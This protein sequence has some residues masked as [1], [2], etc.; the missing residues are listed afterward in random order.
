MGSLSPLTRPNNQKNPNNNETEGVVV[1]ARRHQLQGTSALAA[2]SIQCYPLYS[3]HPHSLIRQ[4]ALAHLLDTCHA[5][6]DGPL[7][8][9][10]AEPQRRRALAAALGHALDE[11]MAVDSEGRVPD[12]RT[13]F[14]LLLRAVIFC[15]A[16]F[17]K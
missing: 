10:A 15:L 11:A 4:V 17:V 7:A 13:A 8:I 1:D 6:P 9:A 5:L 3:C 16:S 2:V 14:M 12:K